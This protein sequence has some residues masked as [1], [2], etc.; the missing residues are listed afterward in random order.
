MYGMIKHCNIIRSDL[1]PMIEFFRLLRW[2]NEYFEMTCL[3][4]GYSPNSNTLKKSKTNALKS[5]ERREA[6]RVVDNSEA[7]RANI[8]PRKGIG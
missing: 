2:I 6:R 5:E 8:P 7:L 3:A 4:A 1:L